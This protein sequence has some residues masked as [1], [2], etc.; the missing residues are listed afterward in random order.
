MK[1][2]LKRLAGFSLGSLVGAVISVLQIPLMTRLMAQ[3]DYGTFSLF[4][5]ILFQIPV[6]LC[7][8]L[9][10]AF[11]REYHS[12]DHKIHVFQ[13]A[14]L[15]PLGVAGLFFL[16][17]VFFYR[18]ISQYLFQN[19][20]ER[21]LVLLGGLWC[22]MGV[23]E[24]FIFL[25]VRMAEQAVRYSKI[26]IVIKLSIFLCTMLFLL[27]GWRTYFG[28]ILGLLLGEL[29]VDFY[30]LYRHRAYFDFSGF[31]MDWP[32]LRR[33]VLYGMPL[34]LLV[35]LQAGLNTMDNLFLHRFA[36][37][38]QLGIY[39]VGRGIVNLF[40]IVTTAF[41]NFW[42]PTALRWYDS[43]REMKH[44][45]FI[46]DAL[47]LVLTGVYLVVML[48][49]P[50]VR[51]VLGDQYQGVAG[52]LGLLSISP[53]MLILSEITTLGIIFQR[54]TQYNLLISAITIIPT[55]LVNMTL[56]PVIGYRGAAIA[57]ATSFIVYYLARTYFSRR[58]GFRIDQKKQV[59]TVTL[60]VGT[61]IYFAL[62]LPWRFAFLAG[63][64]LVEVL[65]QWPTIRTARE[66]RQG[67]GSWDFE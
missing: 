29:A 54:K 63:M 1:A 58:C 17:T 52:I 33:M 46:S 4:K 57:Q 6:L 43:D 39:N 64:T 42:V 18:P 23:L 62:G 45:S 38:D 2:F 51:L 24:R 41:S 11:V 48:V 28:A 14:I 20:N 56:T 15:I 65:I 47:L 19:P 16:A 36:S 31:E 8:G 53:I 25:I 61:G 44:F 40:S 27:L 37:R 26:A 7:V 10:Q 59:L 55:F 12:K 3:G 13:Q 60:M 50:G 35:G 9:D 67:Q 30:L 49:S 32:L 21:L 22:V 5:T 66:I 34:V